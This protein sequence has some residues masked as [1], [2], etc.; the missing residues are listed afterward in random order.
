MEITVKT[1]NGIYKIEPK[2]GAASK[3]SWQIS[4]NGHVVRHLFLYGADLIEVNNKAERAI[5]N[6]IENHQLRLKPDEIP[7]M[8]DEININPLPEYEFEIGDEVWTNT[9]DGGEFCIV[10]GMGLEILADY[11]PKKGE[12]YIEA[13]WL[14][15]LRGIDSSYEF[16]GVSEYDIKDCE[17]VKAMLKRGQ[18]P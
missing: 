14:Y 9:S 3:H 12:F 16:D 11:D 4:Y 6:Y 7:A 5:N 17:E 8:P 13:S 18:T 1:P 10:W 15:N 2:P